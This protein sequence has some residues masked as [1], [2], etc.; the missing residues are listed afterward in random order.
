[1]NVRWYSSKQPM[2][3][4]FQVF[5]RWPWFLQLSKARSVLLS[6]VAYVHCHISHQAC[7]HC[8]GCM[9]TLYTIALAVAGPQCWRQDSYRPWHQSCNWHAIGWQ[10]F[11]WRCKRRQ[12]PSRCC[13]CEARKG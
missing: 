6:V 7:L 3:M 1:M 8:T 9:P 10:R 5:G 13:C 11:W 2:Y 12:A 4:S